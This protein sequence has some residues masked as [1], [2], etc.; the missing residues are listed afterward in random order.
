MELHAYC[1]DFMAQSKGIDRPVERIYHRLGAGEHQR[2]ALDAIE[3]HQR[4]IQSGD[5]GGL[6]ALMSR[7]DPQEISDE[8][9]IELCLA[10]GRTFE[11][12]GNFPKAL[13]Y[14]ENA[15]GRSQEIGDKRH[16][17]LALCRLG[18]VNEEVGEIE[19]VER[20]MYEALDACMATKDDSLMVEVLR[21]MGRM[22]W[23]K[24]EHEKGRKRYMKALE[25]LEKH[26]DPDMLGTIMID[27]ANIHWDGDDF[28][29]A[30]KYGDSAVKILTEEGDLKELARAH[31]TLGLAHE[32]LGEYDESRVHFE[33]AL[34]INESLN[35]IRAS[36]YTKINLAHTLAM[37]RKMG[38]AESTMSHVK[39]Q[40]IQYDLKN[41]LQKVFR[42]EA[43][44]AED[45]GDPSKA[46]YYFEKALGIAK[47]RFP[48]FSHKLAEEYSTILVD[49]GE[50]DRAVD[51]L[52]R[53]LD[54]GAGDIPY[55]KEKLT[56]MIDDINGTAPRPPR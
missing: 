39:D 52:R 1:A 38:R 27:L 16:E 50:N 2:A 36:I 9:W 18:Y 40:V 33:K 28:H 49:R 25:I 17:S 37:D 13:K 45:R 10:A 32:S 30:I 5:S 46:D 20:Y 4:I 42:V 47:E 11:T 43:M 8:T 53:S 56:A 24:S 19:D 44:I 51:V 41:M 29:S 54:M 48:R 31:Q 34:E 22:H 14:Y 35:H 7:F 26:R 12:V 15:Y 3:S 23:K 6:N 55:I 21:G